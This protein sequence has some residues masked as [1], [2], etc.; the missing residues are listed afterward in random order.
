MT[1]TLRTKL[2]VVLFW[3]LCTNFICEICKSRSVI[4]Q[5]DRN[6]YSDLLRAKIGKTRFASYVLVTASDT[7]KFVLF[8]KIIKIVFTIFYL[9]NKSYFASYGF[10]K[11]QPFSFWNRYGYYPDKIPFQFTSIYIKEKD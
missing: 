4:Q 9:L 8:N 11:W 3:I 10:Y 5:V 7:F 2:G 1:Q 6:V